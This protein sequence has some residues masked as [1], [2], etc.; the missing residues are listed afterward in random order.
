MDDV[1]RRTEA[2]LRRV[3]AVESEAAAG[4]AGDV[5]LLLAQWERLRAALEP[6]DP[7]DLEWAR[8]EVD[9]L[10]SALDAMAGRLESLRALKLSLAGEA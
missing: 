8:D 1:L 4:G 5:D 3:A 7:R 2:L 10:L 9:A 6:L